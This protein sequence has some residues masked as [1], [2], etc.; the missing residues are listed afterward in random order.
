MLQTTEGAGMTTYIYSWHLVPDSPIE[1]ELRVAASNVSGA[2][3]QLQEFLEAHDGAE[4]RVHSITRATTTP[5]RSGAAV[6]RAEL[7]AGRASAD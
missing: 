4:W 2:R 6:G 1:V 7:P 5:T 3:R